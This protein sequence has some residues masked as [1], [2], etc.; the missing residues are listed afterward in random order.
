MLLHAD[1]YVTSTFERHNT[2]SD[3]MCHTPEPDVVSLTDKQ[4]E[5]PGLSCCK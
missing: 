5:F 4:V 3:L 2:Q 1:H